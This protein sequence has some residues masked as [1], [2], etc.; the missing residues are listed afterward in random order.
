MKLNRRHFLDQSSRINTQDV[1]RLQIKSD[2]MINQTRK[3]YHT[4]SSKGRQF[5]HRDVEELF[6]DVLDQIRNISDERFKVTLDYL[7]D[8]VYY[9]ERLAV[10]GFTRMHE[11]YCDRNSPQALLKT[12]KKIFHGL[13]IAEMGQGDMATDFCDH[14]L[15]SIILKNIALISNTE[16][17][18]ELRVHCGEMFR[19][20]KSVQASIM[21]DFFKRNQF[22]NYTEYIQSY[23]TTMKTRLAAESVHYFD[24]K[25]RL[26][27]PCFYKTRLHC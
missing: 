18:H 9:I 3:Y 12:K 24:S 11:T 7:A 8:L 10:A 23:E 14:V 5:S 15:F 26:K 25:D 20:I 27:K 19:D 22:K 16:L 1:H 21:V 2:G 17:L 13:F 4:T 6:V